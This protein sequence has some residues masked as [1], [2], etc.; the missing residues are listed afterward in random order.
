MNKY[1]GKPQPSDPY[2]HLAQELSWAFDAACAKGGITAQER[3]VLG[4]ILRLTYGWQGKKQSDPTPIS[5]FVNR[6]SI[7]RQRINEAIKSLTEKNII[8]R[9]K[10]SNCPKYQFSIN[11]YYLTWRV[12]MDFAAILSNIP[13]N[14]L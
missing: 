7:N 8:K 5:W 4:C 2:I 12:K 3:A 9:I 6:L 10:K 13:E 11:K 14:E 1:E